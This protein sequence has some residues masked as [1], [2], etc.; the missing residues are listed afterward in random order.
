MS[1]SSVTV[2]APATLSNLGS[3]FDILG[4]A[5]YGPGDE[6][7]IIPSQQHRTLRIVSIEGDQGKLPY[8]VDKNTCTVAMQAFLN[9]L[10]SK[11][12]FDIR[13]FK[14][15]PLGSGLGSSAASAC[16][17]VVALNEYYETQFPRQELI[18]FAMQGEHIASKGWHA[19]NIAPCILGGITLISDPEK[20]EVDS[21]PVPDSLYVAVLY[22]D[23]EV[24]TSEA[25]ALLPATYS[26][27]MVVNQQAMVAS[28]VAGLCTGNFKLITKGMN[29]LVAVPYRKQLIPHYDKLCEVALDSG[30]AG[31]TISGSGPSIFAACSSE[32]TAKMVAEIWNRFL[33]DKNQ[34]YFTFTSVINQQGAIRIN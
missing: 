28:L 20:I 21:L 30:A 32:D 27:S 2:F 1:R 17:G 33:A 22:Q 4:L 8:E 12:G 7:E 10:H 9:H 13:I 6:V 29:D 19:D 16:A 26:R 31:C 25:R 5:V 34:G 3:G 18:R 23:V 11:E 15:M 14:K 24:L